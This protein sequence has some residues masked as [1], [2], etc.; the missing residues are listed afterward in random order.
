MA[1]LDLHAV[2]KT[3]RSGGKNTL[4]V[5]N[6]ELSVGDGEIVGLLGSSGCGKTTTLRAVAGFVDLS[7][8]AI[9]LDG[10]DIH[11]LPPARRGV[12]MAF[13][14]YA[15]YPPLQVREN[16][17]F[18]LLRDKKS[19]AE[20]DKAVRVIAALLDIDDVLD[21]Y[22][23]SISAGQQQRTSLARALIRRAP[24]TLLDE[25]MSQL[26]PQ[27]RARLRARVKEY[28]A[29]NRLTA[30]F[31]T[32][33]QNEA[34]ALADRIAVMEQGVLQQFA[35][36]AELKSHPANL[37]VAGFIGEPPM[38]LVPASTQPVNDGVRVT[39]LHENSPVG[40]LHMSGGDTGILGERFVHAGIRPHQVVLADDA[41]L[42]GRVIFNQW[43]GD[44]SHVL[45]D[46][47]G[48]RIVAVSTVRLPGL[49]KGAAIGVD[50]PADAV[51]FFD[52]DN[53]AVLRRAP[54]PARQAPA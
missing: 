7:S 26:E 9:R 43:L 31:V 24:V 47:G 50:W 15:L 28:L 21:S 8:G 23:S 29:Q 52:P 16:I 48:L 40:A 3:Y 37:F 41:P 11:R 10:A 20:I 45:I 2:S 36:A 44:Q 38:N 19:R 22:P 6:L 39:L 33:D 51:I 14:G 13:E 42:R 54:H 34:L 30:I 5:D 53:G 18:S 12:A 25:P 35:T 1:T 17:G 4:A 49:R 46:I 32:H 27:L